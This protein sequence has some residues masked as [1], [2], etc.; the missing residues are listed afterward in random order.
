MHTIISSFHLEKMELL[1]LFSQM[2]LFSQVFSLNAM[3][4]TVIGR[5]KEV[6]FRLLVVR[7]QTANKPGPSFAH[8]FG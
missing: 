7:S 3:S 8:N 4:H 1:L 2:L 6:D 5:R